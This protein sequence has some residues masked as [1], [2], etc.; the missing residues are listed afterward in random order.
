M[1]SIIVSKYFVNCRVQDSNVVVFHDKDEVRCQIIQS[2]CRRGIS[3]QELIP[4]DSAIDP[5][6][7]SPWVCALQVNMCLTSCGEAPQSVQMALGS[8]NTLCL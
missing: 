8:P 6:V 3:T 7:S 2:S 1:A 5:Q 4:L